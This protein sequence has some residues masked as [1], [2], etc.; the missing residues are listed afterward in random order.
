MHQC[1]INVAKLLVNLSDVIV[2]DGFLWHDLLQ[3][4]Q[5]AQRFRELA[6]VEVHRRPVELAQRILRVQFYC[7]CQRLNRLLRLVQVELHHADVDVNHGILSVNFQC[8]SVVDLGQLEALL[9]GVDGADAEPGVVVPRILQDRL[10]IA[11]Q[12]LLQ[13]LRDHQLVPEQRVRVGKLRV[14]LDR[15]VEELDC[16]VVLL[17]RR[18]AVPSDDPCHRRSLIVLHQVLRELRQQRL[19]LQVPQ[20]RAVDLHV[21]QPKRLTLVNLGE[22]LDG[23]LVVATLVVDE[24]DGRLHPAAGEMM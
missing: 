3:L 19:L 12:R 8:V 10:P 9:F 13:L 5:L 24:R 17:Q 20:V 21:L 15:A 6:D 14:H 4:L 2:D 22:D 18:K 1:Q 16:R 23:V 7:L 11:S